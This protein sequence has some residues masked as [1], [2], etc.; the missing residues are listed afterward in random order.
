MLTA[1]IVMP[2]VAAIIVGLIPARRNEV[3]LPVGVGLSLLPLALSVY[4]FAVFSAGEPGFQFVEQAD[5]YGPWGISWHLGVDGISLPLVV[6][7][8]LLVPI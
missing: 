4:L 5:W 6:L 2:V 3:L 8:A 1:L 7:T